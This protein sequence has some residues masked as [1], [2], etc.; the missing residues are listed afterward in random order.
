MKHFKS[1]HIWEIWSNS[2]CPTPDFQ[3][4][5]S[6]WPGPLLVQKHGR[7]FQ[8]RSHKLSH[9]RTAVGHFFLFNS[10]MSGDQ[11][12][13]QR[14]GHF[15]DLRKALWNAVFITSSISAKDSLL[16]STYTMKLSHFKWEPSH[17]RFYKNGIK[18]A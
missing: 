12:I 18:L 5:M 11:E 4:R 2:C 8:K 1:C 16:F 14:K 15:R 9:I 3:M 7:Q 17:K 6:N 13:P 10:L